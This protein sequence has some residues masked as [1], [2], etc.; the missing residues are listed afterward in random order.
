[1]LPN[2]V[3]RPQWINDTNDNRLSIWQL[4]HDWWHCKFSLQK[5]TAPSVIT[6]LSNW[7]FLCFQHWNM[8][9]GTLSFPIYSIQL[10]T[11]I[12]TVV[13][14]TLNVIFTSLLW[15]ANCF[16]VAGYSV[17]IL[18]LTLKRLGHFFQNVI[19]FSNVVRYK[20]NIFIWNWSNTM[21][22]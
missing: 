20:C 10:I 14:M 1:M 18:C 5:L 22:I 4:C 9:C 8:K 2:G 12:S 15:F 21:N 11:V 13:N 6:K 16:H 19:L 3:T 17:L 7:W